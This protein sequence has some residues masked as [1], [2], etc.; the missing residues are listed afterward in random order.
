MLGYGRD[1]TAH[2]LVTAQRH[3]VAVGLRFRKLFDEADL[4]LLSTAPQTAFPFEQ[5]ALEGQANL[6]QWANHAG[7]PALSFP[8]GLS[9]DGIPLGL[10]LIGPPLADGQLLAVAQAIRPLLPQLTMPE[11][12]E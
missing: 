5:L 7:R 12:E 2:R 11:L 9:P 8:C 4:L 1:A 10:Q 6:T 3:L